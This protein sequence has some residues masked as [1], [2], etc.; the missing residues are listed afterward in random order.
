MLVPATWLV[1]ISLLS[2]VS[3]RIDAQSVGLTLGRTNSDILNIVGGRP[4]TSY[5]DRHASTVGVTYRF[6]IVAGIA[7][8]PELLLVQRGWAEQ[9]HPTLSLSYVELPVL[10]RLGAVSRDSWPVLPTFTLGSSVAVVTHC[11]LTNPDLARVE[12][13]GCDQRI[14]GSFTEDYGIN[15]VD[16][17]AIAGIGMEVRLSQGTV[18]GLEG[19]YELGLTDIR[20]SPSENSHNSTFFIVANVQARLSR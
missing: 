15:R 16:A 2:S 8:Q 17:G 1:A 11:A 19:R 13:H 12:G 9:S 20:R 4:T 6:P 3:A 14:A 7:I 18:I 5:P 10:L